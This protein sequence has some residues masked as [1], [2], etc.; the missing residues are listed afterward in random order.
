MTIAGKPRSAF[1]ARHCPAQALWQ[2]GRKA[3]RH[4]R[5]QTSSREFG[6]SLLEVITRNPSVAA[7][8][9]PRTSRLLAYARENWVS[10]YGFY[11][12]RPSSIAQN[13]RWVTMFKPRL[14]PREASSQIA[15]RLAIV[16]GEVTMFSGCVQKWATPPVA[17]AFSMIR[18]AR[19]R[20][21][22]GGN[23]IRTPESQF[24]KKPGGIT[25]GLEGA[26]I[27]SADWNKFTSSTN[28]VNLLPCLRSR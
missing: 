23:N 13:S 22:A 15:A 18:R 11:C 27:P 5:T 26:G 9:R 19:K 6:A 17:M 8:L 3:Y 7:K 14:R 24:M 21:S 1:I 25:T 16:C 28:R 12:P 10:A 2:L 20:V 4:W